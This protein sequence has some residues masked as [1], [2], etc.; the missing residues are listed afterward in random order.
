MWVQI[1]I[2]VFRI[3]FHYI[4][5]GGFAVLISRFVIVFWYENADV[6]CSIAIV[7]CIAL[8]VVM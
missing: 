3:V 5:A 8:V 1:F 4:E 2:A 6:N 7:G